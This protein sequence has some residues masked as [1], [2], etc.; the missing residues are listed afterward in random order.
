MRY[1]YCCLLLGYSCFRLI[2]SGGRCRARES[3]VAGL[4]DSLL[5]ISIAEPPPWSRYPHRSTSPSYSHWAV[6]LQTSATR[7]Q[8]WRSE[9]LATSNSER[10]S[11]PAD[12]SGD[13]LLYCAR[14][15]TGKTASF[16]TKLA[17]S[18]HVHVVM[19]ILCRLQSTNKNLPGVTQRTGTLNAVVKKTT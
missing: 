13:A 9:L 1:Y 5:T 3:G 12:W 17:V 6:Q 4:F 16:Q 8:Q 14:V 15:L 7:C 2:L 11:R 10:C 19:Q 18:A